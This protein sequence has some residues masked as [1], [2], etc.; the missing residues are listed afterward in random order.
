MNLVV[1]ARH[2]AQHMRFDVE[3]RW[4]NGDALK[5]AYIVKAALARVRQDHVLIDLR[6]VAGSPGFEGKFL[7]CDRLRRALAPTVRVGLIAA[8][9][10]VD[11]PFVPESMS[12]GADIAL[13]A[14]EP[15]ALRWLSGKDR[16]QRA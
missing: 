12:Q 3:G 1:A 8:P 7:I 5:L 16:A 15:E 4:T 10:L 13:F 6:R 9:E 2:N 11:A 14:A